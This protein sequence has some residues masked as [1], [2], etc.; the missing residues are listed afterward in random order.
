[1]AALERDVLSLKRWLVPAPDDSLVE[2]QVSP[3][4]NSVKN[5]GPQPL[6]APADLL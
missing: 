4:V 6:A 2:S 1:M 3:L 5:D